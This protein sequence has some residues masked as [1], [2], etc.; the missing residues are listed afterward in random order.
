MKLNIFLWRGETK[1]TLSKNSRGSMMME[2]GGDAKQLGVNSKGN[3]DGALTRALIWLKG[4]VHKLERNYFLPL[5]V[6]CSY[7]CGSWHDLG[8]QRK[9]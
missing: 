3:K 9:D 4:S 2:F 5:A 8:D 6:L 1:I 7:R